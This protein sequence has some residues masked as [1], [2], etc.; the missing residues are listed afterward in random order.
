MKEDRYT[1]AL[2]TAK[3]WYRNTAMPDNVKEIFRR[4][5]PELAESKGEKIRNIHP[6]VIKIRG[7]GVEK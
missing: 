7:C 2:N 4:I 1:E 5:F 6:L 3:M